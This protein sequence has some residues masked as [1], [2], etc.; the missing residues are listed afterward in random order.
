[1]TVSLYVGMGLTQA[2]V[3]FREH[4]QNELK[5]SLRATGSFE[6]LEFVG[7]EG[8]TDHDVYLHDRKCTETADLCLFIADH[9]SIGLGMEIVF[10]L[11]TRKPMLI[12]A[13]RDAKITRMLTGMSEVESQMFFRYER[14]EDIVRMLTRLA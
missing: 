9:P 8:G 5:G 4:F 11:M 7:L 14:A 3:E 13:H 6:L 2:P 1:M 10:R 12:C